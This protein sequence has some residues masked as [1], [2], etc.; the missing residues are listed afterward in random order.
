M[1]FDLTP[2]QRRR[3]DTIDSAV[4]ERL[5]GP[6]PGTPDDHFT[7]RR[8]RIAAELGLTGLCLPVEYGG[9]GLGALDTALCLES[10]G[11]ACP[12]T[13]LVF[14]VAAHLLACAVAV[15]DFATGEAA[16]ELLPGLAGGELIAANAMTEDEAGSDVGQ[17]AMK[18]VAD[19]AGYRLTGTKSF[20]S[21]APLADLFVVYAVTSPEDGY[22]GITGF[23]VPR[24]TYGLAV[25][26]PLV[27]L[28]LHGCPAGRVRLSGS[29]VPA[30]YVLGEPG[31]G[32]AIFQ[33]SMGWERACL[34]AIYLG[35]MDEQLRRC[36]AHA[37]QRRQFGRSLGDFQAVAHPI[38]EMR[39]R[40]DAA[41]LL[42]YRACWQMDQGRTD[43]VA[44]SLAKVAASEAVVANSVTAMQVF[45]GS[46]YLATTGIE[47]QLRD[48]LPSTVF[49]GTTQIHR[50][51][52]AKGMGL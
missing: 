42:V 52:I 11:R 23:V 6:V 33:H 9:G 10:F 45:A 47:A 19:A 41:R 1:D 28:G 29:P 13:G 43:T 7:R 14:G 4:R 21:N 20:S 5:G 18:A 26:P 15:R 48:S 35:L 17:L 44:I 12:D 51:V 40:L 34:F 25:G 22:L 8:W 16:A 30:R 27:K 2:S 49:S 31:Q 36:V 24:D 39:Q 50:T 37:R 38:A 46:G 3:C 32:S